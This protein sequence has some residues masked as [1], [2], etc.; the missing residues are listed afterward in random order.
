MRR[1]E[2]PQQPQINVTV[3]EY[4]RGLRRA[5]TLLARLLALRT[6]LRLHD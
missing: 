3:P 2:I 5:D 6:E 1:S 4:R